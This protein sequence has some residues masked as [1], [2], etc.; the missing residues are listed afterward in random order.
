MRF[1]G[2]PKSASSLGSHTE[3]RL[4]RGQVLVR[5][6]AGCRAGAGCAYQAILSAFNY[7]G[8]LTAA[9]FHFETTSAE[10]ERSYT[11]LH[12]EVTHGRFGHEGLGSALLGN[13]L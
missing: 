11:D 7:R 1:A 13:G 3:M 5:V 2:A 12:L 8:I 10:I 6:C 4:K 9:L